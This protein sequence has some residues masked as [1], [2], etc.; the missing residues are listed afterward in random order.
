MGTSGPLHF[1]FYFPP[2]SSTAEI[3]QAIIHIQKD[4]RMQM[5]VHHRATPLSGRTDALVVQHS[6]NEPLKYASH[7]IC[8]GLT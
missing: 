8:L 2:C 1:P 5:Q 6:R 4:E 3:Y 7:N